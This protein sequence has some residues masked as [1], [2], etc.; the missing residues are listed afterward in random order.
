MNKITFLIEKTKTSLKY[1]GS[2]G[3]IISLSVMFSAIC[4]MSLL[5]LSNTISEQVVTGT[6]REKVGGDVQLWAYNKTDDIDEILTLVEELKKEGAVK[7]YAYISSLQNPFYVYSNSMKRY[8]EKYFVSV[9]LY[10]DTKYPLENTI[11]LSKSGISMNELPKISKWCNHY[12]RF[13]KNIGSQ[14][15]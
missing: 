13:C 3:V 11:M 2:T 15:R 10:E 1:L 6:P 4:L 9:K 14:G 8:I 12:R 5:S 7:Q